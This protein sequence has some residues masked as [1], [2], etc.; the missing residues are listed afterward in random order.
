LTQQ[1]A[2][3]VTA[4]WTDQGITTINGTANQI[5]ATTVGNT[6][7]LAF[8]NDVTM[9]NNLVVSGNLTIN[10]TATYVNTQSISAKDPLFEVAND[11]NSTD[12]VDIGYYGRYYDS[13]QTRV[14]FTGLFRDAS[15]AGKFKMFTGLVDEPT[16]VVDT[17]GTGYTVGTLVA[18]FE[19]N[20]AGTANAANALTTARTI[21]ATGDAAW[22]VSF[23][24][25]TNA[26]A[27]LTLANTGVTA[28]TYG[29]TT[30]VPTIAVDS[31]G[32][33]TSASNTNIAFPVLS[34]NSQ[35]GNVVLTTSNVAEGT[36]QYFTTGRVAA[37]LTGAISTVLTTDLT[38]SRA[39]ASNASG[40]LVSSAT[41]DTELG[42]LSG[43]T[44]AVQTQ[45][46]S[47]LNTSTAASTY[48]PLTG[49]T[50]TGALSGTSATFTTTSGSGVSIVTNDVVTLK[51][52]TSA[53][54][55]KNWGF[56]TTNLAGS[57]FGIYQSTS[58]GGDA[59]SAG[60]PRLYFDGLGNVSIGNTSP[61]AKLDVNG[62]FKASGAATFLSSV[63]ATSA[64]F[65]ASNG[66]GLAV[67]NAA[68]TQFRNLI[69]LN[70]GNQIEIGRDTDITQIR[71]GT[72]SANDA[73]TITSAG[74]ITIN[75][76]STTYGMLNVKQV[77]SQIYGA[78]NVYSNN[79][80][81]TFLG[82]GNNGSEVGLEATYGASGAFTP[83]VF[84]T[85]ASERMRITS[86]GNTQPGADNAY[87]LG[88]SGTRWSAVWAA[89]GTIQT[90][91]EREKKDIIDAD[92]GLDFIS[93]LRPVSFKWKV[94]QNI[95]TSEIVKDEEGNPIL[96]E[97][98]KEKT[99][100]VIVPR[101]GK[102]THYG[103]IAQEVEELLDGKDFGGFIHDEET[104]TKGLRYDQFVPLLIKSIQEQQAQIEE[105][106]A[107]IAAK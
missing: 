55:T 87:S 71:L 14:E 100:S 80:T 39:V 63:T 19:G 65:N 13:A 15:D 54:T 41:T 99:E 88:V 73:L 57:D 37:Y 106:K 31:K 56:A 79:G 8:T 28:T 68:N 98:G 32:R 7:T 26:T 25:S 84:R 82:I 74:N 69:I 36:N 20:L 50:L 96:D 46:N 29:T 59:I 92:L 9:P 95:V 104:D 49:G 51:M 38:A 70:S 105:L 16:N 45:L 76:A 97:E 67:R 86:I 94:G 90:S 60:T 10:G 23:D 89:N 44:S 40:K 43:V 58:N 78:I 72:A 81:E 42:Y 102:R 64:F 53:G 103:L 27:A 66:F 6:T 12:A 4:S 107:M 52:N 35:S 91:D 83:I 34:V 17:T 11:N 101:E 62:T 75:S 1:D 93:K 61:A 22:S 18:N 5:A 47:K 85:S 48:L 3:V 33:I 24:G 21:S 77:S 30:A 2:N